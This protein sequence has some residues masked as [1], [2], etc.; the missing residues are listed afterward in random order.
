MSLDITRSLSSRD[1][2]IWH[3]CIC[4]RLTHTSKL[5]SQAHHCRFFGYDSES[6]GYHIY[7]LEK[8]TISIEHNVPFNEQDTHFME[9]TI[10]PGDALAEGEKDK[11][12]QSSQTGICIPICVLGSW[13]FIVGST[14][15]DVQVNT[16][17]SSSSA[18]ACC[19]MF[20]DS[21]FCSFILDLFCFSP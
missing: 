8:S 5:D 14:C 2:G 20:A 4:E 21:S 11:V 6:K 17:V 18:F 15:A 3:C 9:T 16:K 19:A 10:I 12:I 13:R 7:W 1:S